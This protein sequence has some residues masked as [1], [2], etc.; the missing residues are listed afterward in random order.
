MGS[1]V[2]GVFFND[3]TKFHGDL[4]KYENVLGANCKKMYSSKKTKKSYILKRCVMAGMYGNC[5]GVIHFLCGDI[6]VTHNDF[7]V[8]HAW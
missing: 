8:L 7:L 6:I 4:V 2:H 1:S 3:P 5:H